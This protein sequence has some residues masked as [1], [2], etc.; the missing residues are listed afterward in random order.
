[1]VSESDQTERSGVVASAATRTFEA[2]AR[3][4]ADRSWIA[5]FILVVCVIVGSDVYGD[6]LAN[7]DQEAMRQH[8]VDYMGRVEDNRAE[9]V[10]RTQELIK[11]LADALSRKTENYVQ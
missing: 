11:E 3:E 10:R 5:G 4:P 7:A 6:W 8:Y 9:E 2:L 1:M